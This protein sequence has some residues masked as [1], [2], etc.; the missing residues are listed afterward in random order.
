MLCCSLALSINTVWVPTHSTWQ[1]HTHTHIYKSQLTLESQ[2][3]AYNSIQLCVFYRPRG[4]PPA[5]K[6]WRGWC[7][8]EFA[9]AAEHNDQWRQRW[10]GSTQDKRSDCVK[11]LQLCTPNP[12]QYDCAR[13]ENNN[14]WWVATAYSTPVSRTNNCK[15][16]AK[17]R[18]KE[19]LV[20]VLHLLIHYLSHMVLMEFVKLKQT[21]KVK[22]HVFNSHRN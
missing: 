2:E 6:G 17:L 11:Y 15:T 18:E 9:A 8:W 10:P 12:D 13:K 1:T 4:S 21:H 5:P 7:A 22:Q 3:E 20:S 19:R 14:R 16:K